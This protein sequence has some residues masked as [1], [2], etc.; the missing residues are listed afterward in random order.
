MPTRR[1]FVAIL[2]L[3]RVESLTCKATYKFIT[4]FMI[5]TSYTSHLLLQQPFLVLYVAAIRW[6]TTWK[7][8]PWAASPV[9]PPTALFL[10]YSFIIRQ[11]PCFLTLCLYIVNHC[12]WDL[13]VITYKERSAE[14]YTYNREAQQRINLSQGFQRLILVWF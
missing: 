4:L 6:P 9:V 3:V 2:R 8:E 10:F 1:S 14:L 5:S 13:Y 12:M 11:I 7:L